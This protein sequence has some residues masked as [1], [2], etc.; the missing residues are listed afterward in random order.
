MTAAQRAAAA[1]YT[2]AGL[3]VG[4]VPGQPCGP[5][6]YPQQPGSA[7]Q[8][9]PAQQEEQQTRRER[10]G[11]RLQRSILLE[12]GLQPPPGPAAESNC[13]ELAPNPGNPERAALLA[14]AA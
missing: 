7:T 1:G 2:P 14:M 6:G 13:P 5:S 10:P 12:S 4:C 9:S 11:T 3:P 8:L